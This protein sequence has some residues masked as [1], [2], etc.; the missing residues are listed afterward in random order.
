[1][2]R[3][4]VRRDEIVTD[5]LAGR[6][7]DAKEL[8]TRLHYDLEA[9]HTACILWFEDLDPSTARILDH[10]RIAAQVAAAA[11]ARD[12]IF[13]VEG[14]R[15]IRLWATAPRRPLA[16]AVSS[17]RL[18]ATLRAFL[19][20]PQ[21]GLDG[22]RQSFEEA[23]ALRLMMSR[24]ARLARVATYQ[25]L[26]LES[27]LTADLARAQR[28]TRSVLGPIVGTDPRS[29]E[30]RETLSAWIDSHGSIAETS[31]ALYVHRNTVA[32]RIR[33]IETLLG[34]RLDYTR[35]R[36]ALKIAELIPQTLNPAA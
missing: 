25:D 10:A 16:E 6:A 19:G 8:S 9:R 12:S 33:R 36:C 5:I 21:Q 27:L 31:A 13:I 17:E 14:H 34:G 1:M 26:E 3:P 4:D 30:L 32:Q 2:N 28:F 15:E 11:G 24:G 20:S 35:L 22:F 7:H 29:K 23:K 18:P